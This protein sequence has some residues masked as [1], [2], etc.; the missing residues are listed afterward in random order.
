MQKNIGL[1]IID[2]QKGFINEHTQHIPELVSSLQ[3]DSRY[4]SVFASQFINAKDSPY[5]RW[6][7][8]QRFS[9][10]S[11]DSELA[12][13]VSHNTMIVKK[14]GYSSVTDE[15]LEEM[16]HCNLNEIHICGLDTNMCVFITATKLFEENICKPVILKNYCASHSGTSYH[17]AG[18]KLLG[19][20]IGEDQIIE[21]AI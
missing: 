17:D 5:R 18:I 7:S 6:M 12:F 15:L 8:W 3:S 19:K 11:E 10:G 9:E 14:E 16:Y 20:A 4:K 1:L 2:V 21:V 13:Q